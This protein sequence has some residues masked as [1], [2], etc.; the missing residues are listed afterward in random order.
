MNGW[1][2]IEVGWEGAKDVLRIAYSNQKHQYKLSINGNKLTKNFQKF[3]QSNILL[4]LNGIKFSDLKDN[5]KCIQ[6]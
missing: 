6:K 4:K 2:K 1:E 3:N 5:F